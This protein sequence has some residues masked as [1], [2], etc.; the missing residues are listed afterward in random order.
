[1]PRTHAPAGR[2]PGPTGWSRTCTFPMPVTLQQVAIGHGRGSFGR[3][4][5]GDGKH[6]SSKALRPQRLRLPDR[7]RT[8][9][10]QPALRQRGGRHTAGRDR[11][12]MRLQARWLHPRARDAA[13]AVRLACR[14]YGWGDRLHRVK[15]MWRRARCPAAAPACTRQRPDTPARCGAGMPHTPPRPGRCRPETASRPDAPARY[16]PPATGGLMRRDGRTS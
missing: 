14:G 15:R 4:G 9:L 10:L 2:E 3:M 6:G 16:A 12:P 11:R 13:G 8:D 7:G 5:M 1:M